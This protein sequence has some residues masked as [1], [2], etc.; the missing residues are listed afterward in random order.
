MRYRFAQ[1]PLPA[2]AQRA[3]CPLFG[4]HGFARPCGLSVPGPS[5]AAPARGDGARLVAARLGLALS[6]EAIDVLRRGRTLGIYE[7]L[8]AAQAAAIRELTYERERL[9]D[10]TVRKRWQVDGDDDARRMRA[11]VQNDSPRL[12]DFGAF[13][14]HLLAKANAPHL[15]KRIETDIGDMR[16]STDQR[17]RLAARW[18]LRRSTPLRQV[19]AV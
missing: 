13:P 5:P 15:A 11:I 4:A 19:H 16:L 6:S 10:G 3:L 1:T 9:A 12:E 14:P 7:A 2:K 17:K 18:G 8:K